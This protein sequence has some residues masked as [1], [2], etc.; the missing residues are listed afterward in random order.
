MI[1]VAARICLRLAGVVLIK[2]L[3]R[4]GGLA[5]ATWLAPRPL[6]A[7]SIRKLEYGVIVALSGLGYPL[8]APLSAGVLKE[9]IAARQAGSQVLLC[10]GVLHYCLLL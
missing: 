3:M 10:A 9:L 7:I 1:W 2:L 6:A 4:L 8:A 5:W